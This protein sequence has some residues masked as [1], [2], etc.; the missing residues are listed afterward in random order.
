M[1]MWRYAQRRFCGRRYCS[2]R[3]G[4]QR[5]P[6]TAGSRPRSR[7][8]RAARRPGGSEARG[9]VHLGIQRGPSRR[10]LNPYRSGLHASTLAP[11]VTLLR[12]PGNSEVRGRTP[13]PFR[14]Q[15][16]SGTETRDPQLAKGMTA[17]CQAATRSTPFH[18]HHPFLSPPRSS[19]SDRLGAVPTRHQE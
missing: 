13:A 3:T 12:T 10:E 2:W 17:A 5:L 4:R 18:K 8:T 9:S 19:T 6:I 14:K 15:G 11:R 1:L 7:T 16:G